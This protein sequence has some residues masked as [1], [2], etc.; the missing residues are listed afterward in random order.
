A[1]GGSEGAARP[2]EREGFDQGAD[3]EEGDGVMDQ[4]DVEV[5]IDELLGHDWAPW[6]GRSIAGAERGCRMGFPERPDC[7]ASLWVRSAESTGSVNRGKRRSTGVNGRQLDQQGSRA[8]RPCDNRP[9]RKTGV[10]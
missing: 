4:D 9:R 8:S 10:A 3:D 5:R 2:E 1:S 6:L 7:P